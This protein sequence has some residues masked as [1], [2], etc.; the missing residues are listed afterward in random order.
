M[1]QD[2]QRKVMQIK[3][4]KRKLD[5]GIRTMHSATTCVDNEATADPNVAALN[6]SW[7]RDLEVLSKRR[8]RRKQQADVAETHVEMG[9]YPSF[10]LCGLSSSDIAHD[11]QSMGVRVV[12]IATVHARVTLLTSYCWCVCAAAVAQGRWYACFSLCMRD[13]HV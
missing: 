13:I 8:K 3:S 11:L 7:L 2:L 9:V 10:G 12:D 6:E 5:Q 4:E 1:I